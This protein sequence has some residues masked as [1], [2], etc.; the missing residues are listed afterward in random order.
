MR[1]RRRSTFTSTCA[2]VRTCKVH[3]SPSNNLLWDCLLNGHVLCA[4][5]I[6]QHRSTSGGT[7]DVNG[8]W[9]KSRRGSR[10]KPVTSGWDV[11]VIVDFLIQMVL[12]YLSP[13]ELDSILTPLPPAIVIVTARRGS[14]FEQIIAVPGRSSSSSSA[15]ALRPKDPSGIIRESFRPAKEK[16]L[17]FFYY[18]SAST[19]RDIFRLWRVNF[20]IS[21]RFM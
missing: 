17:Y 5:H 6:R 11:V 15:L 3:Y 1:R 2:R 16:G 7:C 18:S 8:C 20:H 9:G 10:K 12:E 13:T 21:T 4:D 19:W 14:S